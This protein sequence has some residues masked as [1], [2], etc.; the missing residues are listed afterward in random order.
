MAR[1]IELLIQMLPWL[2]ANPGRTVAEVAQ[3]FNISTRQVYMLLNLLRETGI[4]L[5][6]GE[7]I[8]IT[9]EDDWIQVNE[10]LNL[11]RPARMNSLQA[12]TLLAGLSFLEQM[13]ALADSGEVREL[14]DKISD[15]LAPERAVDVVTSTEEQENIR[16]IKSAI[17][18]NMCVRIKY[19]SGTTTVD[20]YRVIEPKLLT[21]RDNRTYVRAYCH[22]ASGLRSF[23]ADRIVTLEVLTQ[24]QSVDVEPSAFSDEHNNW[25]PVEVRLSREFL[26]EFD[27]STITNLREIEGALHMSARVANLNWLAS[28]V[29][30]S[31]GGIEILEPIQGRELVRELA[32]TWSAN[33]P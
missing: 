12:T 22:E 29:L 9:I 33:N 28:M 21:T 23:R 30:S 8:E 3:E 17:A 7:Q 31:G 27:Q 13:P 14:I 16:D 10:A 20:S 32:N 24:P 19:A 11:D 5:Y 18:N 6:Y 2:C 4:G 25:V 15:L 26:G 1:D